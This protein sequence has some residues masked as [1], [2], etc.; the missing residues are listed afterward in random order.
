MSIERKK[1]SLWGKIKMFFA[2]IFG[3]NKVKSLPKPIEETKANVVNK[4]EFLSLYKKIKERQ[5]DIN[6]LSR[7]ELI[8]FIKC[9][10]SHFFALGI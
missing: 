2:N 6:T 7:E 8:M 5:V 9:G 10:N 4:E 3:K 1:E